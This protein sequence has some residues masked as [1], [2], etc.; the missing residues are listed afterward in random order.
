MEAIFI[1]LLSTSSNKLATIKRIVERS[2]ML[3]SHKPSYA[4]RLMNLA[5]QHNLL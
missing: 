4:V 5:R 1:R 2:N 3:D